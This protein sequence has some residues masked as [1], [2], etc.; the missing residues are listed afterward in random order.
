MAAAEV[1]A[2]DIMGLQPWAPT[3]GDASINFEENSHGPEKYYPYGPTCT[4]S[5]VAF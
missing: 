4:V 1:R 2:K 3:I 5:G